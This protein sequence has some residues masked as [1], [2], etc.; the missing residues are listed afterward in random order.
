MKYLKKCIVVCFIHVHFYILLVT[1]FILFHF[2]IYCAISYKMYK[3]EK[4]SFQNCTLKTRYY[5]Y[6]CFLQYFIKISLNLNR[7]R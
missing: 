6:I 7:D 2:V 1:K 3:Y 4:A 5:I